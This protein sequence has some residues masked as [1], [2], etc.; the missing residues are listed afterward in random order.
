M[1]FRQQKTELETELVAEPNE[2]ALRSGYRF[3]IYFIDVK[4]DNLPAEPGKQTGTRTGPK[5]LA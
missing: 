4:C 2:L 3:F 5:R 1:S